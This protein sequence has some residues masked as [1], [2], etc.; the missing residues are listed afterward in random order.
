MSVNGISNLN[1]YKPIYSRKSQENNQGF[2]L[3]L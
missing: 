3:D 1:G 2:I